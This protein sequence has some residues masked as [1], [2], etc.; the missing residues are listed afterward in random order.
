MDIPEYVPNFNCPVCE[1][2]KISQSFEIYD[3]EYNIVK[4]AHYS[5]CD[6]CN[7]ISQFPMPD[8]KE[9]SSFYPQ[10]YHSMSPNSLIAKLKYQLRWSGLK[11][12]IHGKGAILDYGCGD[13]AFLNYCGAKMPELM[14]FGYEINNDDEV[15]NLSD[16]VIIYKGSPGYL[17]DNIP[18]CQII[19]MNHVIEHMP[20]LNH[21][22]GR[23]ID[24]LE[25]GGIIE[26]QTPNTDSLERAIFGKRWSGFHAPR[27][28]VIFSKKGIKVLFE[29]L[30][31]NNPSAKGAFNPAGIAVSLASLF[32]SK[33]GG[34][35]NRS[36]ITWLFFLATAIIIYPFD[37]ITKPGIIN[38]KA[39]KQ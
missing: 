2:A 22:L 27:H 16:N 17:L 8:M 20:E 30:K 38:F 34:R 9:L 18:S 35:I 24:K 3:H 13:G 36:S 4:A 29:K 31:L 23:L 21:D 25:P 1:E 19:T 39:Y 11:K 26:G 15:E 5:Q 32:N 37:L 6:N 28:T 10:E 14:F 7:V 12:L 33:K